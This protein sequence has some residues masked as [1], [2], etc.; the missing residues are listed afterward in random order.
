[1]EPAEVKTEPKRPEPKKTEP[2]PEPRPEPTS[3]SPAPRREPMTRD[4]WLWW[5]AWMTF[6]LSIMNAVFLLSNMGHL[7]AIRAILRRLP[8]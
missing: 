2:R 5:C 8:W 6:A 1:M 7:V 3:E 4:K